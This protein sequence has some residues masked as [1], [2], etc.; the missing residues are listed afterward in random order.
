MK[1]YTG[2]FA[3]L[4]KYDAKNM[5]PVS[6]ARFSPK[7][8]EGFNEIALSP[9]VDLL[10]AYKNKQ[11]TE[12]QYKERYIA[13]LDSHKDIVQMVFETLNKIVGEN[14]DL[15]LLCYEK[16]SDFCHRHILAEYLYDKFNL[17]VEEY[18]LQES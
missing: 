1:I 13:E 2:Y 14:Q 7:W 12:V 9:S 4:K 5:F 18:N 11:I 17:E 16:P 3:Q 10:N 8:Y 15:I 6:I